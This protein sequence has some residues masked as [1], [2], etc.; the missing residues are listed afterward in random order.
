[1]LVDI[2]WVITPERLSWI[3]NRE[4]AD[5]IEVRMADGGF[6]LWLTPPKEFE[7]V[8]LAADGKWCICGAW[9]KSLGIYEFSCNPSHEC[10]QFLPEGWDLESFEYSVLGT[11][12]EFDAERFRYLYSRYGPN[13]G[14]VDNVHDLYKI[15]RC[16]FTNPDRFYILEIDW[17]DPEHCGGFRP[18]KN[19]GYLGLSNK[20][21]GYEYLGEEPN[22]KKK[23]DI[24]QFHWHHITIPREQVVYHDPAQ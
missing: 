19:G 4:Y 17:L 23:G 13:Y 24:L 14:L 5:L 15:G 9:R 7:G 6:E 1:M 11:G 12:K 3:Y 21:E 10:S 20:L 22:F 18:H 8:P 2:P 16:R